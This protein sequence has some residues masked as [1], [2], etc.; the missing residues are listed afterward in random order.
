MRKNASKSKKNGIKDVDHLR[1][2][3][4]TKNTRPPQI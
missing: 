4:K 3:L 2:K 1:T